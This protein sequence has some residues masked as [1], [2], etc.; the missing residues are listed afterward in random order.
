MSHTECKAVVS[1]NIVLSDINEEVL[2]ISDS[3]LSVNY[4]YI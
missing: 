4:I 3:K 1:E 2:Y